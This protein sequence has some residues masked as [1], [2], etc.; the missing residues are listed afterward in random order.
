MLLFNQ[1][2]QDGNSTPYTNKDFVSAKFHPAKNSRE[3]Q[4]EDYWGP[5][6]VAQDLR[7]I[8]I[9]SADNY[10]SIIGARINPNNLVD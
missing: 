4:F 7:L 5:C 8:C 6:L 3:R 9:R 1:D 10:E 2:V